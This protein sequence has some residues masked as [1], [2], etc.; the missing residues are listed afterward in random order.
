M[1][2]NLKPLAVDNARAK[3]VILLLADPH[4]LEGKQGGQ[5]K[6]PDPNKVLALR[7]S[8]DL[9]LQGAGRQGSHLLLHAVSDAREHK[10]A[11]KQN[12]VGVK[13]LAD[14]NI[15][16]HDGVVGCQQ[17]DPLPPRA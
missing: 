3:L 13:I 8:D 4:L 2:G 12:D 17:E 5:D 1:E 11:T 9:D 14:I 16:L 15:P 7:R 10:S 6:P